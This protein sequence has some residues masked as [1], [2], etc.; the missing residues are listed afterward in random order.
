MRVALCLILFANPATADDTTAFH[1]TWGTPAQ[2]AGEP[3]K[4]GGTVM[5]APFEIDDTF[6]RQGAI[7]CRLSWGVLADRPAGQT[8]TAF[9]QC[10]EDNVRHYRV[11][12]ER[13]GEALTLRWDFPL[14][15]GPL[16]RC[17][18]SR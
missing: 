6:L 8:A 17:D 3:L 5:A 12:F 1:G 2:C 11:G 7:W 4:P 10:G 15:N 13:K 18:P 14:S 16:Q 9:A